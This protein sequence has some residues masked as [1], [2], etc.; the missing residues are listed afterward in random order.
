MTHPTRAFSGSIINRFTGSKILCQGG[1]NQ[2]GFSRNLNERFLTIVIIHP[3]NFELSFSDLM[4]VKMMIKAS[5]KIS[6]AVLSSATQCRQIL[7][8][9]SE[10]ALYKFPRA[11]RSPCLHASILTSIFIDIPYL[12]IKRSM[13]CLKDCT[14]LETFFE[15]LGKILKIYD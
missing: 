13:F 15:K 3:S 14:D 11:S 7:F 1:S 2:C 10:Y 4:E 9:L 8:N 12:F 5:C 6:S